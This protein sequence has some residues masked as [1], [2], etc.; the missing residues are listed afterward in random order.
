MFRFYATDDSFEN[1]VQELR[2]LT[3]AP[4]AP[5]PAGIVI[6]LN[7]RGGKIES[8][9]CQSVR[10]GPVDKMVGYTTDGGEHRVPVSVVQQVYFWF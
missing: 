5:K 8:F 4:G 6:V 9:D 2:K 3:T 1:N 7:W 10:F